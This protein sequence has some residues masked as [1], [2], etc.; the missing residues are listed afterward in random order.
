MKQ[1]PMCWK[2]ASSITKTVAN[3]LVDGCSASTLVGCK[4]CKEIKDWESAK[5][6]C[7]LIHES[8]DV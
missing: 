8:R 1:I 6:L 5:A 4:E 3:L 7:P 2:C